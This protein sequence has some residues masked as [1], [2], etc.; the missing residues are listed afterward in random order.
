M[1]IGVFMFII[2]PDDIEDAA[3]LLGGGGV[4]RVNQ[5]MGR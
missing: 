5:R 4:V 2:I 1:H 3:R